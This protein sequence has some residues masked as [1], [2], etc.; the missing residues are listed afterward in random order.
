MKFLTEYQWP[1][2]IRELENII[3]R[4]IILAQ[5][6]KINFDFLA[7]DKAKIKAK[8]STLSSNN[9]FN[10]QQQK[11]LEKKNLENALQHAKGKIYGEDGAAALLGLKPT[12]LASQLKKYGINKAVFSEQ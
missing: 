11:S 7:K 1:G 4:Q 12:T 10:V 6:N 3:E 2:N 9:L 5:S 8:V